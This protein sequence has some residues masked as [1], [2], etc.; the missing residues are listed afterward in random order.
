VVQRMSHH[1]L[2]DLLDLG[3][4]VTLNTDDPSVSGLTLTDEYQ[5]AVEVFGLDY[6]AL[7]RVILNAAEAAFLP[8]VER[9]KL[10]AYFKSLLPV[11]QPSVFRPRLASSAI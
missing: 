10:V 9:K 5:V 4:R 1:P 2:L 8:P 7:R 11:M 3:T 6:A